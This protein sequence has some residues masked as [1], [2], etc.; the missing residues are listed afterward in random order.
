MCITVETQRFTFYA[1]YFSP[2][3]LSFRSLL[4]SPPPPPTQTNFRYN[5][6]FPFFPSFLLF[7]S[8]S[9]FVAFLLS[10]SET[11]A[12]NYQIANRLLIT[13]PVKRIPLN[14]TLYISKSLR[15]IFL[16]QGSIY[17]TRRRSLNHWLKIA[18]SSTICQK[19]WMVWQGSKRLFL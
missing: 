9:T 17:N 14:R 10:G 3:L 6:F 11:T 19:D 12:I 4:L 1:L 8:F 5:S 2:V 13:A 16:P 7:I 15:T 18:Q